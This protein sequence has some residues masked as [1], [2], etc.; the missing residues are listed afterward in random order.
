MTTPIAFLTG[1]HRAAEEIVAFFDAAPE[2][3]E[4]TNNT[5]PLLGK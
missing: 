2:V 3:A 1:L 5:A 4:V